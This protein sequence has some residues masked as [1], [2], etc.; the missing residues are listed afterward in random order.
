MLL[1]VPPSLESLLT[2]T[3]SDPAVFAAAL[4]AAFLLGAAHALTPGHGKAVVAAYLV[5]SRGRVSDAICLGG[6][7]TAT[8]TASVFL[9]G[10]ATLFASQHVALDRVY[11]WLSLTSGVLVMATGAWLTWKRAKEKAGGRAHAHEHAHAHPH[12]HGGHGHPHP[13]P[14]RDGRGGLL[15]LG[16]SGGLTPC[17]EALVVLL[18]SISLRQLPLGLAILAA[19]TLGLAAI[20]IGIGIV[21]V[22]A[23]PAVSRAAGLGRWT[24]AV[25]V[26]SAG[27]VTVLGAVIAV[28]AAAGLR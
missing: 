11:P 18:I 23:A 4:G 9:L 1:Q 10:L 16:I 22:L 6:V 28:Q 20:L 2:S 14:H 27:L 3:S 13:H 21:M 8:H 12:S 19:F 26:A 15:S 17:P 24:R 5:G 25:P 7:V